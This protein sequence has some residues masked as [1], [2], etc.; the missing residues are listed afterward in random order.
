MTAMG[1]AIAPDD[2]QGY[3]DALAAEFESF[4]LPAILERLQAGV[5]APPPHELARRMLAIAPAAA[6]V[7][8]MAQQVGP[9][10]YDTRG[11]AV[12]LAGPGRPPISRQAIEQ[13]RRRR[14]VL[15]LQTS[16]ERWIYPTWQFI[17]QGV[18]Q[19]LPEVLN[20]FGEES[21]WSVGTWLTTPRE[22][23]DGLTAVEWLR[24]GR[25]RD[26]LL[27]LAHHAASRWAA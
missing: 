24:Q 18:L 12:V 5:A 26:V 20:A 21:S 16:D 22:E 3:R 8:K 19:G 6:P 27:R 11:V 14:N 4:V 1:R 23:L 15:A 10:F 9:E 13:R 7:N 17:D 2:P 25:D